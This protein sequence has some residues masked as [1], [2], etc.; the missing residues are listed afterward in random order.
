MR[1]KEQWKGDIYVVYTHP[2]P[3]G[4]PTDFLLYDKSKFPIKLT[5]LSSDCLNR[6]LAYKIDMYSF[7]K[8]TNYLYLINKYRVYPFG[9][10]FTLPV[11]AFPEYRLNKLISDQSPDEYFE[12]YYENSNY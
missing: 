4:T 12:R 2:F 6:V 7:K 10:T 11:S 9:F 5:L 3:Y 8:E 1:D